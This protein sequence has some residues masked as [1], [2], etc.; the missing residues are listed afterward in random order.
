MDYC[1]CFK[2][3]N[4]PLRSVFFLVGD[5]IITINIRFFF[6]TEPYITIRLTAKQHNIDICKMSTKGDDIQNCLWWAFLSLTPLQVSN[7]SP[8]IL[9]ASLSHPCLTSTFISFASLC[10]CNRLYLCISHC[11]TLSICP[12]H[13]PCIVLACLSP[14]LCFSLSF[15]LED[16]YRELSKGPL[17][18][19]LM[20]DA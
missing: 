11:I 16:R 1:K 20:K 4:F 7:I 13:V 19:P 6:F 10:L 14:S 9:I 2:T 8:H 12:C 5:F 18:W 17:W 3:E 15:F